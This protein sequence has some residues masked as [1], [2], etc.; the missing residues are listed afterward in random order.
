MN[1]DQ[2]RLNDALRLIGY[3]ID[4]FNKINEQEDVIAVEIKWLADEAIKYL[5]NGIE[6]LFDN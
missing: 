4:S 3:A 1:P 5:K 6:K 2:I